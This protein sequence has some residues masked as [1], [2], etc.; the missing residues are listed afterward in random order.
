MFIYLVVGSIALMMPSTLINLN[1]QGN[2]TEGY[3]IHQVQEQQLNSYLQQRSVEYLAENR[4]SEKFALMEQMQAKTTELIKVIN[5][6]ELK[7]IA[8]TDDRRGQQ[9][10][11]S[12][13]SGQ[14]DMARGPDLQKISDPFGYKPVKF[15]L[16]EGTDSRTS[17]ERAIA[18]YSGFITG[19]DTL[20][21]SHYPELLTEYADILPSG[22]DADQIITTMSGLHSLLLLKN[23]ILAF[24]FQALNLINSD[25]N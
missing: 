10:S 16:A 1:L 19:I 12:V 5:E 3:Y 4:D 2:Y 14:A 21:S 22:T 7:M 11:E 9:V 24:E 25:N 8:S 18:E 20:F 6:A 17:I 13:P 15:Y 23:A